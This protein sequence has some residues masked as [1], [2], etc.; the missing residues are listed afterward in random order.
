MM[1]TFIYVCLVGW[2]GGWH[3]LMILYIDF[4]EDGYLLAAR[5]DD[6]LG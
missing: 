6:Q 4:L 1:W 5:H 2:F 3:I